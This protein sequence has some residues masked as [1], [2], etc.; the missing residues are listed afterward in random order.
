MADSRN[1]EVSSAVRQRVTAA[2]TAQLRRFHD[3]EREGLFCNAHMDS[4]HI[5][6]HCTVSGKAEE[7][8]RMAVAR[9][10]LSARAYDR[11]RKVA[12]T[13]A[14]LDGAKTILPQHIGEAI[15]YRSLDRKTQ[16]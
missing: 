4:R 14:D 8:L 13:V 1:G 12:R 15:Q 3:A 11:V 7:L 16:L 5:R 6:S 2:R 10:G 9:L